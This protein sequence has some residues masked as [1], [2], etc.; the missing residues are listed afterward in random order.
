M[1]SRIDQ[2]VIIGPCIPACD[3]VSRSVR[4]VK[5]RRKVKRSEDVAAC[6]DDG[7][8]NITAATH[9]IGYVRFIG[10]PDQMLFVFTVYLYADQTADKRGRTKQNTAVI[11]EGQRGVVRR[12][13]F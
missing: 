9:S 11:G 12:R 7:E 6:A 3:E 10:I 5:A 13:A 4:T 1:Q 8:K 2:R